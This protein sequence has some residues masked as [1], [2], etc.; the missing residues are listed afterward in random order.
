LCIS[1]GYPTNR[2][3]NTHW[4]KLARLIAKRGIALTLIGG[5][6]EGRD[7]RLI[8]ANLVDVRHKILEGGSDFG[9]FFDGLHDIDL[10]IASDGGTA[11]LCSMKKPV[12]SVFGSS[13]WRR[14]APFGW[15]NVV[16]TRN[17]VCSPC[18]QFSTQEI[19]GCLTR[20]CMAGI[21]PEAVLAVATSNGLDFSMARGVHV[22]RGVSHRYEA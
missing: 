16:I 10:V 7:L 4:L 12:L 5:P 6:G 3:A 19:N 17:L 11:H 2:W 14:F 21:T 8:S 18:V 13:P 20:E 15:N 9:R 1:A 22:C